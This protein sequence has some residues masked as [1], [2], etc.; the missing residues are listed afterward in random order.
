M[1][2]TNDTYKGI[3]TDVGSNF[4]YGTAVIGGA[5]FFQGYHRISISNGTYYDNVG[6]YA[7]AFY[8][9]CVPTTRNL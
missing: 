7:G 6:T 4:S 3:F 2:N 1:L 9:N 5:M 8:M